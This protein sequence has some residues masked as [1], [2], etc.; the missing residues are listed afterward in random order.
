MSG[1]IVYAIQTHA[2]ATPYRAA[3]SD[4]RGDFSYADLDIFSTRFALRLQSY[5][6]VP[7]DRVVMVASRSALMLACVIGTF[8]AGCIHVPLDPKMP[9]ERLRYIL[10]DIAPALVIADG[11][12][13]ER[14]REALPEAAPVL[15]VSDV[16]R[17]RD[18]DDSALRDACVRALPLPDLDA[19]ATAY[20]IYT[21]G[22]TG[23]PKGV[24]IA[25]RAIIDFFDGT[26]RVYEVTA[27]SRC[28]SFSPLHFD[29]FLMDMLFPLAQGAH[30]YVHDDVVV[31]DIMLDA[32][33]AHEVTHFSAWGMMLGLLAQAERFGSAPLPHLK[34]ILTGTDVP[35]IK[36]VQRWMRKTHG[37]Q[38]INA[39]GPTEAT[40]AA[41]AHVIREIEPERRMLYPI[42][43][44]LE[45]VKVLLV[46]DDGRAIDTPD[47]PGELMVGGT[48]VMQGY[49]HLPEETAAR[50]TQV[51]GVPFYRTGDLCRW[52]DD[53]SLFYMGR[54][55][56]EVKLGGY[57]IHLN[58]VRRVIDSV[59]QVHASE[60]VVLDTRIGEPVLA[61]AVLF[62]Q[63][64]AAD[65]EPRLAA[66]RRRLAGELQAYM[67]P[68]YLTA[69][70][71]F[72][73]LSSGKTDRKALLSIL[74]QRIN[75]SHQ[76][77]V[78]S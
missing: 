33:C 65:T 32:L 1:H 78:N 51:G 52:L 57:R 71:E 56:N 77:E 9:A 22:S 66:I 6:C 58:E 47:T 67:V 24:L 42:G 40:C 39:Y 36:T 62:E 13:A 76:E 48:Q 38:V 68:R 34:Q 50:L 70:D 14:V 53:G 2:Q 69:L 44:P 27:Q 19:S 4:S 23:R 21:S 31:P 72:P 11:E 45:H 28:A 30:L 55:D 26:R 73:M 29:V 60:V 5:G 3:L 25:H 63:A 61:A 74:Q 7:G 18:D 37:V 10:A 8:K 46:G 16:E 64:H 43:V 12:L 59:P 15:R 20:C 54:R 17:L 41:T 35:D 75:T 49:W